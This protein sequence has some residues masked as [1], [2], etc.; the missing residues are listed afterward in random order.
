MTSVSA[1]TIPGFAEPHEGVRHFFG[2]RHGHALDDLGNVAR[3]SLR[4]VHGT[5]VLILD[6]PVPPQ[7]V[8]PG[9]WDAVVTN[10]PRVML[11]IRTADCVP[12]LIHDP[13][14]Q[15][16][17]AIHAGW[18]GAVAEIVPKTIEVLRSRFGSDPPSL[19]MGIGPSAGSCCYE[20]DEPVLAP[21]RR[22]FP[23][24]QRV[25]RKTDH[26]KARLDLRGLICA[27]AEAQGVSS[28]HIHSVG[29]C[30]ICNPALFYSYRRDGVV[31]ATMV[32]GIVLV[33]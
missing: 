8:V 10:Q 33:P 23:D 12:V 30:T 21:L 15:V 26:N 11:T 24:W 20:V 17:A 9:E 5:D 29:L 1:I 3:V 25:V 32:S 6:G 2:T 27:Q 16:V 31:N 7:D 28:P 4:Q 22:T 14:R 13:V 19:R 18:R